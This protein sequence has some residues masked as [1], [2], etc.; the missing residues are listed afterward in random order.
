MRIMGMRAVLNINHVQ[1]PFFVA[2]L[3]G[4]SFFPGDLVGNTFLGDL[5]RF[6]RLS[7]TKI[8][9]ICAAVNELIAYLRHRLN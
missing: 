4:E 6:F 8:I 2:F 5:N 1:A 7:S 9:F 3:A